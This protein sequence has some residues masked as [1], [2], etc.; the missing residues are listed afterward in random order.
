MRFVWLD[1]GEAQPVPVNPDQVCL[2]LKSQ[3]PGC[4]RVMFGAVTGGSFEV[5][6]TGSVEEIAARLQGGAPQDAAA[7][8]PGAKADRARPGPG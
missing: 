4:T 3:R 5:I 8:Q 6:A 2:L 1:C 7:L